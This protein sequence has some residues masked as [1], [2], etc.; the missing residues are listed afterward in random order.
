MIRIS[1][2]W[3]LFYKFFLPVVWIVFF[4]I[5]IGVLLITIKPAAAIV[6]GG[7]FFYLGG[8]TFLY[9]T[10]LR[11]KRVEGDDSHLYVTNYFKTFRYTFDSIAKIT[12][13][14]LLIFKIVTLH[15][16]EKTSFGR[17]IYF[18]RRR[19]VWEEYLFQHDALAGIAQKN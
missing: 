18:I 11:L 7:I 19:R 9:F 13:A 17:R 2:D 5:V 12:T 15:F 8:V 6:L 10:L 3:T 1:S 16:A 4:G 14:D